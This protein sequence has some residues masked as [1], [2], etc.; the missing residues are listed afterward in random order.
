MPALEGALVGTTYTKATASCPGVDID[1][2]QGLAA[3]L[4]RKTLNAASVQAQ[5]NSAA[6]KATLAR[7]KKVYRA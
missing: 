1:K 2:H 5:C 7:T 4:G 3:K 6:A